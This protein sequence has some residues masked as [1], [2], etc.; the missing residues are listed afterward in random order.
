MKKKIK[1][2]FSQITTRGGDHGESTLFNGER[3]RKDDPLF[4][5]LGD[6][7]ELSSSMGVAIAGLK[8][9]GPL[10]ADDPRTVRWL[11]AMDDIQGKLIILGGMAANP[12]NRSR[13]KL[14]PLTEK[15]TEKLE[16]YQKELMELTAISRELIHPG[17]TLFSAWID[18]ARTVC[19]RC[20]RR[21]VKEIRVS[22]MT[23]LIPGQIYLNRLSDFLFISARYWEQISE[24]N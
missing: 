22:V 4:F 2:E 11:E 23:H 20:E 12:D 17:K 19:R 1:Y 24:E 13:L 9:F 15:D 21:V 18:V 10:S 8:R 5:L 14:N 7:D 3:R 16:F 6:L